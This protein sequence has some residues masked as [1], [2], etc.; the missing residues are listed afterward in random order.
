MAKLTIG[1]QTVTVDDA[2]LSLPPDQQQKTVDEISASLGNQ[3]QQPVTD[4]S[5]SAQT[6]AQQQ[7]F[8][9]PKPQPVGSPDMAG[10]IAATMGGL[11]NGIPVLGPAVQKT[12]DAMLAGGGMLADQFT[13]NQGPDLGGRMQALEE[14]RSQLADANPIA[15]VAGNLGG[16][17][18]SYG[19]LGTL[20]AADQAFQFAKGGQ[21]VAQTAPSIGAQAI[22]MA[23]NTAQKVG[24]SFL[25][26]LG[27]GTADSIVRGNKPTQALADNLLPALGA[28][29]IPG[30]VDGATAVGR[31]VGRKLEPLVG[32]VVDPVKEAL[33]RTGMAFQRDADA[34]LAISKA[35]ELVAAEN[36]LDLVNAQRGGET[37]RALSRSVANQ[38]PEAR[39]K[40]AAAADNT[41]QSQHFR[42]ADFIKRAAGGNVDDLAFQ[43]AQKKAAQAANDPL[44]WKA[45]SA[46]AAK[47][48]WNKPIS[49]LMQ[50]DAFRAA[51][52]GAESAGSNK[53]AVAGYKAIKNPFTF[54]ED[55]TA[56][57][58]MRSDP[59]R[60]RVAAAQAKVDEA[61]ITQNLGDY[62]R[63]NNELN[64]ANAL[65]EDAL[66]NDG[67]VALPSLQFW[68]Q[69]KINLG[70][71]E[72]A[73][74]NNGNLGLASD[75]G[76]IRKKLVSSL[77]QAVP[78]Y[79]A[80]RSSA[81]SFFGADDALE[82]GKVFANNTRDLPEAQAAFNA[83]K[84]A[85][86]SAFR[87]G[88]ASELI[89]KIKD[90]RFRSNVIDQA[91]GSPAKREL[92]ETVFGPAKARQLE[93]YIRVEDLADK[94]R[95]SLGNSTTA[96]QLVELGIGGGAGLAITGGDWKGALSGAA[97]VKGGKFLGQRADSKVMEE[98]ARL[99]TSGNRKDLE[100][101]VNQASLSPKWMA[102]LEQIS[103]G[104]QIAGRGAVDGTNG[105]GPSRNPT[106]NG[107][108]RITVSGAQVAQ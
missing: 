18:G 47:A 52:N 68:N 4:A 97:L 102:A 29:V 12:S 17:I 81:A 59:A 71:A 20:G 84:P 1:N 82:A 89:D 31:V 95:T 99:L 51:V 38:S 87:T 27:L 26:T 88:Y 57:L 23:G 104:L 86:Q 107:P 93:A 5:L 83:M 35:D 2:F 90:G 10:S 37:T 22:G 61:S 60:A 44:Y 30:A 14:R 76:G 56:R 24:N 64:K 9:A 78:D 34:G 63:A 80:A 101:A 15:N 46:P 74:K 66:K 11:V 91:F 85:E 73:A 65:L 49:Q 8:F 106:G 70:D 92:F 77:D 79:A 67:P 41:F 13:G 94:L 98:V 42:A 96:R 48:I 69:V 36:G 103:N 39:A 7:Q 3:A 58:R 43:A 62:T 105:N 25:S 54:G 40:F 19:L 33:R 72:I 53:A 100:M 50:S 108:L 16:A 28:G 6:S 21:A 75:I 45:N 55:G 32:A